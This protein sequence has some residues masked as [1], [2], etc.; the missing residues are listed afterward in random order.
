MLVTTLVRLVKDRKFSVTVSSVS[1]DISNGRPDATHVITKL[2]KTKRQGWDSRIN[3]TGGGSESLRIS[4]LEALY[5]FRVSFLS[6][7]I[8]LGY[9]FDVMADIVSGHSLEYVFVLKG[10]TWYFLGY[11]VIHV[12]IF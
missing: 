10:K 2:S 11:H 12:R 5:G 1:V 8:F 4:Y 9:E 3:V 7:C 6:L